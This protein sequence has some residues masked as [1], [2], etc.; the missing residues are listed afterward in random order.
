[1][2]RYNDVGQAGNDGLHESLEA[3]WAAQQAHWSGDQLELPHSRNCKGCVRPRL[4]LQQHLPKTRC[5]VNG[6]KNCAAGSADFTDTITD[7]FHGVFFRVCL[8]IESTKVLHKAEAAVLFSHNKDWAVKFAPSRLHYTKLEPFCD[9]LL[10]LFSMGIWN[11]ELL[12]VNRFL[13]EECDVMHVC[14]RLALVVF[15]RTN[16]L[17][18]FEENI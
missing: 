7:V 14:G 13:A 1:M 9:M 8:C 11:F 2:R 3:G 5:E 12:D 4:W 6:W 17:M 15:V 16:S 18:I 10:H